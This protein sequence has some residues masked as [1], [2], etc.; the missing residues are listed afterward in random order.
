MQGLLNDV[1]NTV[2]LLHYVDYGSR[3]CS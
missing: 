3:P 1:W 2:C